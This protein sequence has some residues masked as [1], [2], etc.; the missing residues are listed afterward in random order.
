VT[1]AGVQRSAER[2]DALAHADQPDT[3]HD[4]C[5]AAASA[6][7]VDAYGQ[8]LLTVA[9]MDRRGR[10]AGMAWNHEATHDPGL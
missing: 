7:V 6:V 2:G 10:R 1:W 4:A 3:G 5:P 9:E 8:V